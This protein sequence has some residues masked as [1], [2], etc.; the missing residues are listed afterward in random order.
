MSTATSR[1]AEHAADTRGA[2]VAAARSLFAAQ[3]YAATG[4]EQ[5]V[6]TARVTRG[7]L[8]HHFKDKADLFRAVVEATATGVASR[9][10]A[11]LLTRV[12]GQPRDPWIEV[13]AGLQ[14][15]LDVCL[16]PE[17]QRIVLIEGPAVLGPAAWA[18]LVDAHGLGLLQDWL[19]QAVEGG[20]ID[21][22]PIE[23]L[24]RLLSALIAE[25]SLLIARADDPAEARR[26][27]GL[28]IER[29]LLGLQPRPD[30]G[31]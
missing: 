11:D 30:A 27:A 14:A 3:G 7:A 22:L 16:D 13:R 8:Y 18:A 2:L 28:T 1:R 4:T 31:P 26:L 15:Y 25:A 24:A 17:F 9:L 23:P 19:A 6:S 10:T 5:I 21:P 12:E 29:I 20:Q